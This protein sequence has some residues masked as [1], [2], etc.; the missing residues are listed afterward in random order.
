[1]PLRFAAAGG[2]G[3]SYLGWRM[4]GPTNLLLICLSAFSAVFV[5]LTVLAGVMRAL[6]AAFPGR[7]ASG[8]AAVVAAVTAAVSS[9]YPGTRITR[10]EE[11]R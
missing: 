11:Q 8:D 3:G 4:T 9:V 7:V 2:G 10:I 6:V 1:M 5:L